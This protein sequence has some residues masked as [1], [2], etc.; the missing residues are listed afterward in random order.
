[1]TEQD[2][3]KTWEALRRYYP[4][5][6]RA[7]DPQ[8]MEAYLDALEAYPAAA[9]NNACKAY[10]QD[11]GRYWPDVADIVA[12]IPQ[13]PK[14]PTRAP[15]TAEMLVGN[16]RAWAIVNR[17]EMPEGMTP[18]EATEWRRAQTA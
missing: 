3:R 2:I 6:S 17:L 18:H 11:G 7:N 15:V 4:N 13:Q 1:M 12:R 14:D 5:S 9:V 10:V 16:V 8:T